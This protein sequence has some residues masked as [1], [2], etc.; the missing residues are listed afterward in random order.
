MLKKVV[1]GTLLIGLIGILV[2]GAVIRTV[3][4]T[5]NVAEA[6]GLGQ[7]QSVRDAGEALAQGQG[8]GRYAQASGNG[9]SAG[10][11]DRLYPNY[12]DR[13]KR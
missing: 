11:V 12:D 7:G 5:D 8:Q 10:T 6:R 1:L 13:Q 4:K 3:D 2:A 9:Q